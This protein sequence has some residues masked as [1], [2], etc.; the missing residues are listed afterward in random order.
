VTASLP[1]SVKGSR[2]VEKRTIT[3][4]LLPE[5]RAGL[6]ALAESLETLT[7]RVQI[8]NDVPTAAGK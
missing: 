5:S 1:P 3:E 7:E 8:W 6:L 2:P 4:C